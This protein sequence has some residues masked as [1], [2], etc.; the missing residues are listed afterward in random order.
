[1]S[2]LKFLFYLSSICKPNRLFAFIKL[3][4]KS[5]KKNIHNYSNKNKRELNERYQLQSQAIFNLVKS[6][7]FNERDLTVVIHAILK[8]GCNVLNVERASYWLF[9]NNQE[10]LNCELVYNKLRDEVTFEEHRI[11]KIN[12]PIYF[13]EI[14]NE[15]VFVSND[16]VNDEKAKE[17]L[18][19]YSQKINL[20]ALLDAPIRIGGKVVGVISLE[21]VGKPRVWQPDEIFFSGLLADYVALAMVSNE[22]MQ[23]EEKIKNLNELY[24]KRIQEE[25]Q[26]S[27][28]RFVYGIAHEINNPTGTIQATL[29]LIR[30]ER[31]SLFDETKNLNLILTREEKSIVEDFFLQSIQTRYIPTGL[32]RK[33]LKDNIQKELEKYSIPSS[34]VLADKCVDAGIYNFPSKYK[35]ILQH[36]K[37]ELILEFLIQNILI[38]KGFMA[39][40]SSIQ[41]ITNIIQNLKK[42]FHEDP[43]S[44]KILT[45]IEET[46]ETTMILFYDKIKHKVEIIR[47]YQ[48]VDMIY[49]YPDELIQLWTNLIQNALQAM[50]YQGILE[51]HIQEVYVENQNYIQVN[52]V[53]S[54]KGI[55]EEIQDRIFEPFFST[56]AVGEGTGIGLDICRKIVNYHNG[57][58][59]FQSQP[60]RTVFTVLLPKTL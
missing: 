34:F 25:K 59:F 44:R 9:Q 3:K 24:N 57:K 26:A 1:M 5:H 12:I 22:K 15:R 36:P 56:K 39:I 17:F 30:S 2:I 13:F 46:I 55:P 11:F 31:K 60:G 28:S 52:I 51:I 43:K 10:F 33:K 53:D 45:S 8:T 32:E 21:E 35:E 14:L 7:V 16:V 42:Y 18:E 27:M 47:K 20:G 37:A 49:C 54:G 6:S 50:D 58:I 48:K 23:Q 29:D 4:C 40:E 41:R 38:E 19:I